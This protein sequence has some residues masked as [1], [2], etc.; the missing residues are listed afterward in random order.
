MK[1]QPGA[2]DLQSVGDLVV[3]VAIFEFFLST[4]IVSHHQTKSYSQV[5]CH[6]A[7]SL[8]WNS[9]WF[10][11][12]LS[13]SNRPVSINKQQIVVSSHGFASRCV[14][15]WSTQKMN[16]LPIPNHIHQ[17][18]IKGPRLMAPWTKHYPT[19]N[20]DRS[21]GLELVHKLPQV[22]DCQWGAAIIFIAS[23]L[24]PLMEQGRFVRQLW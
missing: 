3:R 4:P 8:F 18:S 11:S 17:L 13:I 14:Q 6:P 19:P 2:M 22:T 23:R 15:R 10:S 1:L 12:C 5:V 7:I 21:T 9:C 16:G 20:T 24:L